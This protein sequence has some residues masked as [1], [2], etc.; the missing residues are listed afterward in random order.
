VNFGADVSLSPKS[1]QAFEIYVEEGFGEHD[2]FQDATDSGEC[3][4]LEEGEASR[5]WNIRCCEERRMTNA[6]FRWQRR[7]R[8]N[9]VRLV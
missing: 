6:P 8:F 2:P 7:S 3:L 4:E 9:Q 1:L 5:V